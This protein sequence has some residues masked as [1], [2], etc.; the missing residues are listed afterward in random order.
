MTCVLVT[1]GAG[2]IGANF[3]YF[4]RQEHPDWHLLNLDLLTYAGNL[5]SLSGFQDDA[6]YTFVRGDIADRA[7]VEDLFTR[8]PITRVVHFAAESHVDRSILDPGVFV[9]TNVIGT[10]TL[11]EAA[12]QAWKDPAAAS[13]CR[14]LHVSTDEVYGS[15]GPGDPPVTETAPYAPRS[16]YAASKAGADFLARAYFHTY[17][18]PVLVTNC[19]NNYGPYQFPEKLIP[20]CLCQALEGK[21]I[22]IYGQGTNVR[23]WL[24]VEDHCQALAQVLEQGRVGETYNIGGL[25]EMA[26]L[27]VVRLLLDSLQELRPGLGDLTRLITLVPDR[28]GHDWRYALNIDK[29]QA[30]LGWRPRVTLAAGLKRT[31]AWYLSH[32]D[33]LDRVR[34]QVYRDFLQ[35]QYGARVTGKGGPKP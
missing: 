30:Q 34:S 22:P 10:H 21:P 25:S 33:W 6:R 18:L 3:L 19:T 31:I 15:L 11:L 9:R 13:S 1:G 2:F 26:N 24:F 20:F 27:D 7:L 17:G 16:P 29:I 14:F 35:Q 8:Y 4:L 28:P 23:D 12:R 5:E 32:Q